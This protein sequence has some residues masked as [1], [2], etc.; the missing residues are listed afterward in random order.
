MAIQTFAPDA[1]V[2][3]GKI[4]TKRESLSAADTFTFVNNG[5]IALRVLAGATE[6][7]L[8]VV[9]QQKLDG[10][11]PTSREIVIKE[12]TKYIGYFEPSVYNSE[13]GKVE[14]TISAATGVVIELL[15]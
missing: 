15:E 2:T 7:K 5:K 6:C 14:F 12:Q 10:I 3:T 4:P 9:F 8:K 13:E 1:P 11:A